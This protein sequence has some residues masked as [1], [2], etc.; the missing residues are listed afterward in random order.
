VGILVKKG[1]LFYVFTAPLASKHF[2]YPFLGHTKATAL[3]RKPP[4][5]GW[6]ELLSICEHQEEVDKPLDLLA[7]G[8]TPIDYFTDSLCFT[9]SPVTDQK[10]KHRCSFLL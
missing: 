4:L 8:H 10:F 3:G 2:P 9:L 5:S 1:I 6:I 7:T